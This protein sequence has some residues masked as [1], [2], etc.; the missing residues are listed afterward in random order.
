MNKLWT[1]MHSTFILLNNYYFISRY[2]L[3]ICILKWQI[4]L[5]YRYICNP[6]IYCHLFVEI[7]NKG[8]DVKGDCKFAGGTYCCR[9]Y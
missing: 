6:L 1:I 9:K 4:T 2:N 8:N 7:V 3:H 5:L